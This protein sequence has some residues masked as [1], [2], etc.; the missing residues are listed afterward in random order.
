MTKPKILVP[1]RT[2]LKGI[3]AG[4]AA[5]T[6]A[7][8]AFAV[9]ETVKI[10]LVGPK[11]GPLALFF[12]E[13][14]YAVEH[15]LK[16]T[17]NSIK[18]NGT[19]HPLE[20]ITKDSQSNP[21][22]AS[23]VAQDLI[24]KDKVHI[25]STFATPE[26]V[27]PVADQCEL[28]GMPCVSNDD[29]IESF[30]FGRHG[31]PKKGFEWTYNFFFT[32]S[33]LLK[34]LMAGW[35]RLPSNKTIGVLWANDDDGRIFAQVMTP[36]MKKAGFTV[37]DPGRFD[38]PANNFSPEIDAF[39]SNKAELIF[40][41]IPGPDFTVFFNQAAQQGFKPKVIGA[42]K[43]DE[44]PEGVYPYG[45]RAAN[46]MTEVWWSKYHPYSSGLTNQSSIDFAEEYEKTANK[47]SSMALG[48]RH[49]LLEV[50][51]DALKR[52]QK[53]DSPESIRDALRDTDYK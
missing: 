19:V 32:G 40:A 44:F 22:R 35:A 8:P 49:S 38:L 14:S 48:F 25:V 52:T 10:G 39:K 33:G 15:A 9:P 18:I 4:A 50:A 3:A 45:E 36:E 6:I 13:M 34:T 5:S 43:V 2:V 28:N 29:P 1:R 21:N 30:F 26:T 46:F 20:I 17:N 7:T 23:E 51:I 31:D 12:E 42:G 27:N 11:T 41:V 53:L 16:A 37:V 47:Q 24:L